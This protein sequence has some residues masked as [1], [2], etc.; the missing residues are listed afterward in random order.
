MSPTRPAL[1]GD[2]GS[3]LGPL[4]MECTRHHFKVF[5]GFFV[6][7]VVW[8]LFGY[9]RRFS[10]LSLSFYRSR[11]VM[12]RMRFWAFL[13]LMFLNMSMPAHARTWLWIVFVVC[14]LTPIPPHV[15]MVWGGS[16]GRAS[17][18]RS[19]DPMFE[20]RQEHKKTMAIV[21]SE[22]KML[23][24]LAVRVPNPRIKLYARIRMIRYAR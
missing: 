6:A 8:V 24:W 10:L 17:D 1:A 2:W 7:N 13:F 21:F 16:V 9:I 23:C 3:K 19:K 22:S 5:A 4:V 20:P 18:W 11:L 14:S 12:C 15:A